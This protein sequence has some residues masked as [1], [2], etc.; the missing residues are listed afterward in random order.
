MLPN[1]SLL[2]FLHLFL[3]LWQ[4]GGA[5]HL[6]FRGPFPGPS[7]SSCGF[8]NILPFHPDMEVKSIHSQC[9]TMLFLVRVMWLIMPCARFYLAGHKPHVLL[10]WVIRVCSLD[11][12]LCASTNIDQFV[13]LPLQGK[14]QL[15]MSP[16]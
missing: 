15:Q 4:W 5:V 14:L 12:P 13:W 8:D 6:L 10:A 3:H 7:G 1:L 16:H 11:W 2:S 9:L